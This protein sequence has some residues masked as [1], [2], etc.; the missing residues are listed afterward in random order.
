MPVPS[1]TGQLRW[2]AS[3]DANSTP[4]VFGFFDPENWRHQ[5]PYREE[6]SLFYCAAQL[7]HL[8]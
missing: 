3:A 2:V 4:L 6:L 1:S 7:V 8:C 5:Y